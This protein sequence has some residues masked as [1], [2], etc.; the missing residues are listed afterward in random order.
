[1]PLRTNERLLI[2]QSPD[3]TARLA[4]DVVVE[5]LSTS[6]QPQSIA[7]A[8]GST[9]KLLYSTLAKR[10]Y[11]ERIPWRQVR[12]FWADERAVPPD[13]PDSNYRMAVESLLAP[14]VVPADHIYRMATEG[15]QEARPPDSA[16]AAYEQ[17]IRGIVPSGPA[18]IPVFDLILLGVG[19]DG[20]TASLFPGS[21][22]LSESRRLVVP[23][24]APSQNA[25]RMTMTYPLLK[26]ARNILFFV[27]GSAK[28]E[29][30]ARILVDNDPTL[31]VSAVRDAPGRITWV[32]DAEAARLVA[33]SRPE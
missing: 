28:A 27:T 15:G 18:G 14:L 5:A 2:G 9:P 1:M 10:P 29:I 31:P 4:A 16:A 25:W 7:L 30:M 20:H 6:R 8:G 23:N 3:E 12:W 33:P 26:A 24:Y 17:A 21:A 32:L 11:S 13:H 19:P 22:A